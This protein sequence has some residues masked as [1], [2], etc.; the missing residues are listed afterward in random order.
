MVSS[1]KCEVRD[2]VSWDFEPRIKE[3]NAL[4]EKD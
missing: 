2:F 1:I 3:L 4:F